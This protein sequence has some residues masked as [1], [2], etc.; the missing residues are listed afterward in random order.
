MIIINSSW[1]PV[2][3]TDSNANCWNSNSIKDPITNE[4]LHQRILNHHYTVLMEKVK[5]PIIGHDLLLPN[6]RKLRV[7]NS[8][9]FTLDT[10]AGFDSEYGTVLCV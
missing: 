3:M 5:A 7:I 6:K 2:G 10:K 4:V 8:E 1:Q 9:E